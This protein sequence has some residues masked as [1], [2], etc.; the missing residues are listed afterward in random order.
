MLKT[1]FVEVHTAWVTVDDPPLP[2][3]HNAICGVGSAKNQRGNRVACARKPQLI[4]PEQGKISLFANRYF[5]NV[6]AAQT[7]G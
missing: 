7:T 3:N 6:I 2:C 5:T 4:Q 1:Q